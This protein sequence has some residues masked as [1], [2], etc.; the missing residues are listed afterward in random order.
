MNRS[1]R[2]KS[3]QLLGELLASGLNDTR[4][5]GYFASATDRLANSL[6]RLGK[7]SDAGEQYAE[8]LK[9]LEPL[10]HAR[11]NEQDISYPLAET[12]TGAG[13]LSERLAEAAPTPA[14]RLKHWQEAQDWYQKSLNT[15]TTIPNPARFSSSGVEATLSD[16]VSRRLAR[17]NLEIRSLEST[18]N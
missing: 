1:S 13:A 5:Q 7:M 14:S 18:G 4:T 17:C 6:L 2:T 8:S 3:K 9:F 12:Y 15:W 11:P 16:E 10:V